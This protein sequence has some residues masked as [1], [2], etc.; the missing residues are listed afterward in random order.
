[1]PMTE[2]AFVDQD[3]SSMV[4]RMH[5]DGHYITSKRHFR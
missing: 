1:M 5:A 4:A 2:C 3:D